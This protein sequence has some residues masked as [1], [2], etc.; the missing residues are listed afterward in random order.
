MGVIN[1]YA[2][3]ILSLLD[4]QTQGVAPASLGEQVMPTLDTFWNFA[5]DKPIEY[6]FVY[7]GPITTPGAFWTLT[8]PAG[9]TWWV[10]GCGV[11]QYNRDTTS[12][13]VVMSQMINR[14]S[15]TFPVRVNGTS[16]TALVVAG[17]SN[18]AQAQFS[19]PYILNEGDE[20][21][22]SCTFITAAVALGWDVAAFW[23]I[24]KLK[25]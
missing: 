1:R 18:G 24:L 21:L 16:A 6:E 3:G 14:A 7:T 20:L 4:S 10:Y 25:V 2:R 8:V 15:W 13:S 22:T 5:A 11:E 23:Y 12:A 19:N 17:C 9:E